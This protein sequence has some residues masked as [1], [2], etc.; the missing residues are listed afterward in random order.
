MFY[1]LG[2]RQ[3]GNFNRFRLDPPAPLRTLISF[4]V[5]AEHEIEQNGLKKESVV[6]V[7][8]YHLLR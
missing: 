5:E 1:Q 3:F 8:F 7:C 4:A 6:D 2:L